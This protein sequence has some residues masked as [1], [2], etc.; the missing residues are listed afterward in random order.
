MEKVI[1]H[2]VPARD[3]SLAD[4]SQKFQVSEDYI[5]RENP[6][7]QEK[8]LVPAGQELRLTFYT[9]PLDRG[10]DVQTQSDGREKSATAP[11]TSTAKEKVAT[12][13]NAAR[14]TVAA[15]TVIREEKVPMT[16]L[17]LELVIILILGAA[18]LILALLLRRERKDKSVEKA[19][20]TPNLG[21]DIEDYEARCRGLDREKIVACY[22]GC[23]EKRLT[24]Q[25]IA[26][27][28][29][30]CDKNPEIGEKS[31][32][33]PRRQQTQQKK[34]LPSKKTP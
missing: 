22:Y 31:H 8:F 23:D 25:H 28:H 16:A 14:E 2:Y 11:P 27:H 9:G 32:P 6:Q 26:R 20:V 1:M 15:P 19:V 3:E 30:R 34:N 21:E 4:I 7:I 13:E 10:A 17:Y 18:C 12:Q 29:K 5:M 33:Q 24:A